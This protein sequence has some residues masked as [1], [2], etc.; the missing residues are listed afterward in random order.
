MKKTRIFRDLGT[1]EIY[2]LDDL[3]TQFETMQAE[4]REE[5]EGWTFAACLREWLRC[6]DLVEIFN[7]SVRYSY[8]YAGKIHTGKR[9]IATHSA[10]DVV[11][12]LEELLLDDGT[13]NFEIVE[14]TR[15]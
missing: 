12:I 13:E 7:F 3:K 8:E 15:A 6:S 9:Y 4:N 14:V 5:W 2:T 10:D 1:D 11:E